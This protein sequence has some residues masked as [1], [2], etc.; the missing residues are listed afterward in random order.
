MG[1]GNVWVRDSVFVAH[2]HYVNGCCDEAV[3]VTRGLS[4]FFFK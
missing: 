2:A 3:R 4:A 1:G